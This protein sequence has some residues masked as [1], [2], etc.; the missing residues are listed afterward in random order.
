MSNTAA[1]RKPTHEVEEGPLSDCDFAEMLFEMS[2]GDGRLM[3]AFQEWVRFD[4]E[5]KDRARFWSENAARLSDALHDAER[6]VKALQGAI[7]ALE[8]AH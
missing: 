8:P 7:D 4:L 5:P 3:G 1:P 6:S 2:M